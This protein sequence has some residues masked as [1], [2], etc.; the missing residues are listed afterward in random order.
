MRN[1]QYV[2]LTSVFFVVVAVLIG[3]VMLPHIQAKR[4]RDRGYASIR[5]TIPYYRIHDDLDTSK[6]SID[7]IKTIHDI[8][9]QYDVNFEKMSATNYNKAE[10]LLFET[11]N[12]I[13][14]SLRRVKYPMGIQYIYGVAGSDNIASK[15]SL[16]YT[17]RKGLPKAV[18][19]RIMPR[20]YIL[21]LDG[22]VKRLENEHDGTHVYVMK[23]NIQQ[24]K[25]FVLTSNLGE[26]LRNRNDYVVVQRMLQDPFLVKG[27]KI[28]MRVYMLIVV[29]PTSRVEFFYYNDGFMY[30]TIDPFR[31]KSTNSNEVI[32]T[33]LS[34]RDMYLDKPLTHK[35]FFKWLGKQ[36]AIKLQNEIGK[37][38]AFLQAA[39][40]P[41]FVEENRFV[42]GTKF[43][44]YGVDVAPNTQLECSVMEVNKGPDLTYKDARDR[45]LKLRMVYD[46]LCIAGV[47]SYPNGYANNGFIRV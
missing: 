12:D 39:Y 24:Q 46:A 42:P 44:I 3:L 13:D 34:G 30:Y 5:R 11:L 1:L 27:H 19:E 18:Q 33:G 16:A 8:G 23:K 6:E 15:S 7:I 35:D 31:A 9:E 10:F 25:G 43:L 17:L 21:E 41:S 45:D 40:E 22:D 37:L 26:I 28:N 4:L 29:R 2:C 38:I 32:T 36:S 47:I 20:T 14:N